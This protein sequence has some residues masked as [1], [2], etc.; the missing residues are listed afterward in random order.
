MRT[1]EA[2]VKSIISEEKYVIIE[3]NPNI[4]FTLKKSHDNFINLYNFLKLKNTYLFTYKKPNFMSVDRNYI[5]DIRE[6]KI[7]IILESIQG[8]LNITS[9]FPRLT[10]Y[11]YEIRLCGKLKHKRLLVTEEQ[12]KCLKQHKTYKLTFQKAFG[13]NLY[14]VLE[15]ETAFDHT[16]DIYNI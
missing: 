8:F 13:H 12:K 14:E 3:C 7:H 6:P 9:E 16:D 15:F 10:T 2:T 1:I 5:I 4:E 11:S